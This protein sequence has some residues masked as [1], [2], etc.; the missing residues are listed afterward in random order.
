M[1]KSEHQ[2]QVAY[3]DWV[4][5][6]ANSDFRYELIFA[7]PN[8]AK[9]GSDIKLRMIQAKK[10]KAEGLI[11]GVPDIFIAYP[12]SLP[13]EGYIFPG[14]FIEMKVGKNKTSD[15]QKLMIE[16]LRNVGYQVAI[17]YNAEEAREFTQSYFSTK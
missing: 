3:F 12:V 13:D 9:Y 2:E 1:K 10:M 8:G 15:N 4:R 5:L 7:I 11:S 6:K 17:S 16:N 14:A